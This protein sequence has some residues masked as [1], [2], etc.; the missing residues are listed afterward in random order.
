MHCFFWVRV[1]LVKLRNMLTFFSIYFD[2]YCV[3]L[4][5]IDILTMVFK[6]ELLMSA[7]APVLLQQ[8]TC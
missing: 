2:A 4:K 1:I 5:E 8:Q 6:Q 7:I 3:S